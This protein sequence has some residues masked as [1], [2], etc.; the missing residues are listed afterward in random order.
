MQTLFVESFE[1]ANP[2]IDLEF[3]YQAKLDEVLRTA[4]QA[5][6]GPD[7]IQSPG[8]AFVAEYVNAGLIAPLDEFSQQ[9]GWNQKIF[10]WAYDVGKLGG[11]LYSLP[12]TYET[13][14]LYYNKKVFA[15]NGLKPPTNRADLEQAAK[16][17]KAKGI[18]PFVNAN[19]GWKGVNE[20]IM[21]LLWNNYSGPDNVYKALKGQLRWDDPTMVEPVKIFN[22]WMQKG[23]LSGDKGAY[24]SNDFDVV[25]A[26]FA[27]GKGAMNMEGT[28]GF[29]GRPNE[30]KKNPDDWD[31][32]P[33]PAM[34]DGVTPVYSMAIGSTVSLNAKSKNQAA[35]AKVLA[36]IYGD[37][38]RAAQIIHD[39][40]GEWVVPMK[41]NSA[42]FPV[43]TDKRFIR[44]L[45]AIADASQK[46]NYG[47]A[48]W[49]FWPAKSDQYVIEQMDAVFTG[50]ITPEQFAQKL[51]ETFAKEL[52]DGKVPPI[53]NRQ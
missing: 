37:P 25:G 21:T 22:D 4:V 32:V 50:D 45:E 34:R 6:S 9:Y 24:F 10:P 1:K 23:W 2:D 29:N 16:T 26:N 19:K 18:I 48:T 11:K 7:I 44:A 28:W 43:D 36:W 31:W 8:P 42:D 40:P 30:F 27:S 47:Y 12:L 41:L 35:A 51:Q 14:I 15:D 17:L 49:T 33:F 52:A 5:G 13:M 53:P 46:G 20:W 3:V 38:K 39:I